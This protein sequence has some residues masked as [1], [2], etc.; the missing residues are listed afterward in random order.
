MAK[1]KK[2]KSQQSLD[3]DY[4]FACP[5]YSISCPDFLK[6]VSK[7]SDESLIESKSTAEMNQLWP[8]M[9][10]GD[11][12]QDSRIG[13]FTQYVLSTCWNVL[14][15]QGYM[16]ENYDLGFTAMWSQEHHQNSD[17]PEHVH[18]DFSQ[19]VAFY[20]LEVTDDGSAMVLHDPRPGKVQIDLQPQDIKNITHASRQVFI[21]PKAGDLIITNAYLAH[22]FTR[23]MSK[24]PT[25]FVHMNI[26]AWPHR[27][28]SCSA[29]G[30]E[31]I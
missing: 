23:N 6:S 2:S 17:M 20:F 3:V 11:F 25:K 13:D 14:V 7:V 27:A 5:V 19:L 26:A 12:S 9:M 31:I 22:S 30:P 8:H 28:Q 21:K 16:M 29:E 18:S 24:T 15:S 10:S 1:P 4:F